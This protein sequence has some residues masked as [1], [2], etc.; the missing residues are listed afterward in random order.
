LRDLTDNEKKLIADIAF[1]G[2]RIAADII[3]LYFSL[4]ISDIERNIE[5]YEKR[6]LLDDCPHSRAIGDNNSETCLDCGRTI[7]F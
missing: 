6:M 4:K 7:Y 5:N 3:N 2:A 1:A